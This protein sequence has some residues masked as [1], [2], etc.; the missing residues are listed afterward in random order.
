[1]PYKLRKAPKRDLYW[2]VSEDGRHHS[3]EPLPKS[4]AESQMKALYIAMSK[5]K[6][7]K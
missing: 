1:M 3:K 6:L 5:E 4:R 7:R 2:V